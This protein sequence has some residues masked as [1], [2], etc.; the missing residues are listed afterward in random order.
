MDDDASSRFRR[1]LDSLDVPALVIQGGEVRYGNEAARREA[2][3]GDV[4]DLLDDAGA[5]RSVH[6]PEDAMRVVVPEP[7][8][9]KARIAIEE[10]EEWLIEATLDGDGDGRSG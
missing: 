7:S 8:E 5:T 10:I 3:P 4:A 2:G 9:D 6:G 1:R